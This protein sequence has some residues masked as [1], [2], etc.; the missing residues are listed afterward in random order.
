[1]LEMLNSDEDEAG[2]RHVKMTF[3]GLCCALGVTLPFVLMGPAFPECVCHLL[4]SCRRPQWMVAVVV[5]HHLR[6]LQFTQ[7]VQMA[8]HFLSV[9]GRVPLSMF[10]M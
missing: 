6:T 1:M 4:L 9:S 8:K 2:F 5:K 3:Y 10:M 7:P